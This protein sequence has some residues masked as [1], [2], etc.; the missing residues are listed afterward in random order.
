MTAIIAQL[1][2]SGLLLGGLYALVAFG[3]SLIY[4][5]VRILNFAHGTLLA[6]GGIAAS[7]I[8]AV[9]KL[10][11]V[12]IAVV[13]VLVFLVFGYLMHIYLLDP[14]KKRNPFEATIGT[15]LVTVGLLLIISD[16]AAEIAGPTP[17]NIPLE[18]HAYIVGEVII[19][20]AELYILG[21]ITLFTIALHLFLKKTWFGRAIRAVTQSPLGAN[22]CGIRSKQIHAQT[23]AV[24]CGI[25]AI[26]GVLWSLKF[27][28]DPYG[29]FDLTV[30]AFTII[31][32]GGIGN[33]VGALLAGLFLGLAEV[34]TSFLWASDWAPAVSIVLLLVILVVFPRGLAS[35]RK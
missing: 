28:V 26:A 35:V 34:F 23:V 18:F 29:G 32:L 16:L 6:I 30:R 2:I 25:V 13:L 9:Y 3:L 4:G 31:I 24:G 15:V 11:P 27:P 33:L 8:F 12:L 20:R 19:Q 21:G 1:V 22:I 10:N 5:V 17:K 7:I 14:L